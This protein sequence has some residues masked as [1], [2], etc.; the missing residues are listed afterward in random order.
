MV[1]FN[2]LNSNAGVIQTFATVILVLITGYYAQLTNRIAKGT[3]TAARAA[4]QTLQESQQQR[5]DGT[6]PIIAINVVGIT[7]KGSPYVKQFNVKLRNIGIGPALDVSLKIQH[8][9]FTYTIY[10]PYG[11]EELA[12]MGPATLDILGIGDSN[13]YHVRLADTDEHK[14]G[15]ETFK[16]GLLI[17]SYKDIHERKFHSEQIISA[18]YEGNEFV[19]T[20]GTTS[21]HYDPPVK[22]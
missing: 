2:W 8:E 13:E 14:I 1:V 19:I 21:L 7:A 17:A 9:Q 4:E 16:T 3:N 11:L 15:Y 5:L 10:D 18:R 20:P 6:L 12:G 22:K